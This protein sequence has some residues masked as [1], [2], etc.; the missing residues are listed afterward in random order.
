[1][2][3][4]A[5][6]EVA[7]YYKETGQKFPKSLNRGMADRDKLEKTYA[8]AEVHLENIPG[9]LEYCQAGDRTE[10]QLLRAKLELEQFI[11]GVEAIS[12]MPKQAPKHRGLLL[13]KF[14]QAQEI[15]LEVKGQIDTFGQTIESPLESYPQDKDTPF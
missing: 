12:E 4:W 11:S 8:L 7:N 5:L 3:T 13:E 15:V 2:K 9:L 10:T 1:M 14:F 6:E